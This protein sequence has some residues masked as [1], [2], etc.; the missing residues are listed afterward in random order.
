MPPG[1]RNSHQK[2]V[3]HGDIS[4]GNILITSKDQRGHRGIL[5][6]LD[7]AIDI[8]KRNDPSDDVLSVIAP[9]TFS[10]YFILLTMLVSRELDLLCLRSC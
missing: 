8:N 5:I 6:D 10:S 2:S 3:L 7:N 4:L 1:H 9:C